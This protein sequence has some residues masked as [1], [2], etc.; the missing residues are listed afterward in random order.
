MS[1]NFTPAAYHTV[2]PY[3]IVKGAAA[4]I[5]FYKWIFGAVEV[6]RMAGP[7]GSVMHGEFKIG[8]STIMIGEENE[9]WGA[10]GPLTIGG[11]P[12][13]LCVYFPDVDARVEAAVAAGATVVKPV[14][15]HF[16]GDRSG[17]VSDPFG[18]QWTLATHIEDVSHEEMNRRMNE[19]MKGMQPA[20]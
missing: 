4:A 8:D 18:H 14:M 3:L 7:D 12:V 2:T 11:S 13:G 17:T 9:A 5:D 1:V 20:A 16:Y 19:M 6:M 15:D 10:K